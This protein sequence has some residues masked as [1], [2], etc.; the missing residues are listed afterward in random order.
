MND[1]EKKAV[2]IKDSIE[3][4]KNTDL[5]INTIDGVDLRTYNYAVKVVLNLIE[6]Q[7]KEIEGKKCVIETQSH[8]EEVLEEVIEKQ[9]KE[10]NKLQ[11]ECNEENKKCMLLAVENQSL[12]EKLKNSISK[13]KIKKDLETCEKVYEREMKPYQREYGLDVT[14]LS[15]KEK[16]KLINTR[17][18]LITQMETYRQL[19]GGKNNEKERYGDI[20]RI[21]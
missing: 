8:N 7:K 3:I 12:K 20:R 19:L 18:C 15:K 2:E 9:Q 14:Y 1:E 21:R 5:D 10:I 16:E 11:K 17:N 6:K 4:L 13:D